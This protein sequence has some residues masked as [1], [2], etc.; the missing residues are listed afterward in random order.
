MIIHLTKSFWFMVSNHVF[1]DTQ[2]KKCLSLVIFSLAN[3]SNTKIPEFL[4]ASLRAVQIP[5]FLYRVQKADILPVSKIPALSRVGH[6]QPFHL[7]AFISHLIEH[8]TSHREYRRVKC[9]F[10]CSW[11]FHDLVVPFKDS[12]RE[13][14]VH[15]QTPI[16][17][18][19]PYSL[20]PLLTHSYFDHLSLYI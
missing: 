6:P 8:L 3:W 19:A 18:P 1:P 15:V 17:P 14:V 13:E 5:G 9:I 11:A 16:H 20:P 12:E 4:L 10:L 7:R 2:H